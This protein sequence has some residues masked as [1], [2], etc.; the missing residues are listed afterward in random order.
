MKLFKITPTFDV[1]YWAL[2]IWAL[3]VPYWVDTAHTIGC[4]ST[5]MVT[6]RPLSQLWGGDKRTFHC[7][8]VAEGEHQ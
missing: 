4:E 6:F 2:V 3:I 7:K 8:P 5:G 1:W